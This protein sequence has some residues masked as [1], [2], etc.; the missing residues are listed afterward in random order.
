MSKILRFEVEEKA[1]KCSY[2]TCPVFNS[3]EP[4]CKDIFGIDCG[5]YDLSTLKLI[6]ENDH[7]FS[8]KNCYSVFYKNGDE[9]NDS[10]FSKEDAFELAKNLEK[11][12]YKVIVAKN[13]GNGWET[14]YETK[15][16]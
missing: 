10:Y 1:T 3:C 8:E 14:V 2:Q 7:T 6:E 9:A 11:D 5:K 12:G 15:S 4:P 16:K 13:T